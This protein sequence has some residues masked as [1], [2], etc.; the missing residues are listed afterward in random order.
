MCWA[1]LYRL[2][3]KAIASLNDHT[4]LLKDIEDLQ[5]SHSPEI[6][7]RNIKFFFNKWHARK[8]ENI[9]QYLKTFKKEWVDSANNKWYEG[10]ARHVP[11]ND[12]GLEGKNGFIKR[13]SHTTRASWRRFLFRQCCWYDA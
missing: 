4:N 8:D 10:A 13:N 12:N 3:T 7:E 5:I 1:L 6:F 9:D 11:A 2:V